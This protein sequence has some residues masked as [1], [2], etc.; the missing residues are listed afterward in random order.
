MSD[1]D[2]QLPGLRV[3]E[4]WPNRWTASNT[5]IITTHLEA[6]QFHV[7]KAEKFPMHFILNGTAQDLKSPG[8]DRG[9]ILGEDRAY[10]VHANGEAFGRVRPQVAIHEFDDAG[11]ALSRHL[12]PVGQRALYVA[13]EG[14]HRL[15]ITI[16]AQGVGRFSIGE[17]E[18]LPA[19]GVRSAGEGVH[20]AGEAPEAQSPQNIQTFDELKDFWLESP[21]LFERLAEASYEQLGPLIHQLRAEQ[22]QL[23]Q[24]VDRLAQQNQDLMRR[25]DQV[26][27]H[28]ARQELRSV[29]ADTDGVRISSAATREQP[30]D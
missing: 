20:L 21:E 26:S 23:H 17:L 8:Q 25:L 4:G 10:A 22:Q 16:R 6:G 5:K 1:Q 13:A 27:A 15:V 7:S 28:L 24:T 9:V 2:F 19:G 30:H 12:V 3:K 18:F 11:K 29:F 14:V